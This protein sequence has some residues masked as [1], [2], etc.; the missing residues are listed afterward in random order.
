M[1]LPRR[2]C[3]CRKPGAFFEMRRAGTLPGL[4]ASSPALRP[5][6]CARPMTGCPHAGTA[7]PAAGRGSG[8]SLT[9]KSAARAARHPEGRCRSCRRLCP[10]LLSRSW[11]EPGRLRGKR[12]PEKRLERRER[13]SFS[14]NCEKRSITGLAPLKSR[15]PASTGFGAPPREPRW[16]RERLAVEDAHFQLRTRLLGV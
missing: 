12:F 1:F 15:E 6:L 14:T 5:A 10:A 7:R 3:G 13:K 11:P 2:A 4:R 16:M 9:E 8:R